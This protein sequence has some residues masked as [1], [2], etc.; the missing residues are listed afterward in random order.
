MLLNIN[1]NKIKK[2]QHFQS[3]IFKKKL[4]INVNILYLI[5]KIFKLIPKQI[6]SF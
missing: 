6:L 4:I 5:Y 1:Q 3:S 2:F